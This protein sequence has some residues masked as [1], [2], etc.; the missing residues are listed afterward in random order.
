MGAPEQASMPIRQDA[1]L[2][3]ELSNWSNAEL[4]P[5]VL[6]AAE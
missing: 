1:I 3:N 5:E 2:A 4:V 6:L